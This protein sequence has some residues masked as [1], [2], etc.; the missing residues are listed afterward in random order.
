MAKVRKTR[1]GPYKGLTLAQ[2]TN[3]NMAAIRR[4]NEAEVLLDDAK[5]LVDRC[6]FLIRRGEFLHQQALMFNVQAQELIA[7]ARKSGTELSAIKQRC[8][9]LFD[10]MT[11]PQKRKFTRALKAKR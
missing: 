6:G 9:A 3:R 10:A 1:G 11:P 2:A 7:D 8:E 4:R 5:K